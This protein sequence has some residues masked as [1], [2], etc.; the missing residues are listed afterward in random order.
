MSGLPMK[1]DTGVTARMTR[2]TS[3]MAL[4]VVMALAVFGVGGSGSG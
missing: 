4:M 1:A 3:F 2:A